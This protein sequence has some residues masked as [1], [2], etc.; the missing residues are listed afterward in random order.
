MISRAIWEKH[1]RECFSKTYKIVL[2]D[3]LDSI[4]GLIA[5]KLNNQSRV[6]FLYILLHNLHRYIIGS[7]HRL[8]YH[9]VS[10][11]NFQLQQSH[12]RLAPVEC[13]LFLSFQSNCIKSFLL[14][15][16]HQC[17]LCI[18]I[19]NYVLFF[20]VFFRVYWKTRT[21][22]PPDNGRRTTDTGQTME[23][24]DNDGK[25]GQTMEK[26]DNDGK[27]GQR[28]KRWTNDEKTDN[29][30][31]DGQTMEKTDN[32]GKDGQT[33]EKTDKRWKRRTNDGKD[34]QTMEKTDAFSNR[35]TFHEYI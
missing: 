20:C 34:G 6:S 32:D 21:R 35:P 30:G 10:F 15:V 5:L 16:F 27:D 11:C 22:T 28:W 29:D 2:T 25:D 12:S 17:G 23:K 14:P 19:S 9:L 33:M 26:T 31:K 13:I 24:T 1:A 18:L 7:L 3:F 4:L 8:R